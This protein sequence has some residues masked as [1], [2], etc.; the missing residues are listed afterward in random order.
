MFVNDPQVQI[1]EAE[2]LIRQIIN[3]LIK[4]CTYSNI[5]SIM[6]FCS[7]NT[8]KTYARIIL[9]RLDKSIEITSRGVGG[10][11]KMRKKNKNDHDMSIYIKIK[12]NKNHS[13]H[14][15]H[16]IILQEKALHLIS[17]G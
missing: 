17:N 2:S 15:Q 16:S 10:N 7:N 14:Q 4:I 9:Q 11:D 12:D 1:K 3:T 13:H 8:K 6:S 5:L